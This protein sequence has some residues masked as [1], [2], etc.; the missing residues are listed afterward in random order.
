MKICIISDAHGN[1][2]A[3]EA[4]LK[5]L[6]T[7]SVDKI[8]CL[9][10][11]IIG[12]TKSEEVVQ[13]VIS[14]KDKIICVR[15]NRE[16]Y[17]IEGM[18]EFVHGKKTTQEQL[19]S[20]NFI[21]RQLSDSSKEFINKLPEEILYEVE[22]KKIYI[23]HYPMNKDGE[24]KKHIKVPSLEQSEELFSDIEAD[25]FLYGHTHEKNYHENNNKFYIN[26]GTLGCPGKTNFAPY[27]ILEIIN[28]EVRYEQLQVSYNVDEVIRDIEEMKLPRYKN[29]LNLYYGREC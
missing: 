17:I 2:N 4:V 12:A 28:K 23:A 24:F 5:E 15:G 10:D 14:L 21:K 16:K 27:G 26:P 20:S 8:I 29:V 13:K 9:G 6:E 1:L 7:K 18:P 3:L 11:L 22:N 25:V 19:E